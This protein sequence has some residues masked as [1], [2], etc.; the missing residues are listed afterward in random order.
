MASN[1]VIRQLRAAEVASTIENTIEQ[2]AKWVAGDGKD[3]QRVALADGI[4]ERRFVPPPAPASD[5]D[6]SSGSGVP[7]GLV[8]ADLGQA[9]TPEAA[10]GVE[11]TERPR[12]PRP[13]VISAAER[14]AMLRQSNRVTEANYPTTRSSS[15]STPV[16]PR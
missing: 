7:T 1:F 5:F 6:C 8:I 16:R 2:I 12:P 9:P 13:R 4:R 11:V 3:D 15:T 10:R 14:L